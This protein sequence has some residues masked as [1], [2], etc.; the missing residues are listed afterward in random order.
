VKVYGNPLV[1][2][3]TTHDVAGGVAKQDPPGE[4]VTTYPV[5][6]EPPS[7]AGGDHDTVTCRS[8]GTTDVTEAA[9][10]TD[11]GVMTPE[12]TDETPV[13]A[14]FDATTVNV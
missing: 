11:R 3:D 12:A 7:L 14:T 2:P 13:P 6:G 10:G 5:T 4:P 9:P 1:R 8:S